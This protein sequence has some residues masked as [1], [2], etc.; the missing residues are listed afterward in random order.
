MD[1]FATPK[2]T[3]EQYLDLAPHAG[4]SL[5]E[6]IGSQFLVRE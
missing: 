2:L 5:L 6:E 4:A 1:T 3:I